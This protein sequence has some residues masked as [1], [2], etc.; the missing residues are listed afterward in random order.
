MTGRIYSV[1]PVL[2]LSN[3]LM[4][5]V[6]LTHKVRLVS[7][8]A[9]IHRENSTLVRRKLGQLFQ[10]Y[11][12]ITGMDEVRIAQNRVLQA[13]ERFVSAQERRREATTLV[14]AIQSK[15]KDLYA[16]LDNT[17]RGEERYVH[18]I[19]QEHSILK[20]ER[21][22][23]QEFQR[24]EREEREYFAALSSAVKESHEK[25]RAQAERTK[26]W[27]IIGSIIGT[28]I[29][30]IGSSVNSEM[31]MRELRRFIRESLQKRDDQDVSANVQEALSSHMKQLSVIVNEMKNISFLRSD[32]DLGHLNELVR[33][34]HNKVNSETTTTSQMTDEI[35]KSLKKQEVCFERNF[36][37]MK[38][39][40][41]SQKIQIAD[42]QVVVLPY[43]TDERLQQ[44]LQKFQ[45]MVTCCTIASIVV[46]LLCKYFG[47]V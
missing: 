2:H 22:A 16:E 41:T 47:L 23:V 45:L 34:L 32:H 27:S 38:S 21:S 25:E 29:G 9:G 19:T 30:I 12:E 46:P 15:L 39:I 40:V 8:P 11:E 17:T 5:R 42:D 7:N 18:L 10:W 24:Y 3:I 43:S 4:T 1:M 14:A 44:Q 36:Q 26:Y 6:I 35:L 13:E 31:K 37:E 20:E 28:V 33:L